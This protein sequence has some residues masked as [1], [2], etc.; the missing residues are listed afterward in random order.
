MSVIQGNRLLSTSYPFLFN[1]SLFKLDKIISEPKES[2]SNSVVFLLKGNNNYQYVLK[3]TMLKKKSNTYNELIKRNLTYV[4]TEMY[5]IMKYLI[6]QKITPHMF[7]YIDDLVNINRNKLNKYI[8]NKLLN[9]D[10]DFTYIT[11]LFNETSDKNVKLIT[12]RDFKKKVNNSSLSVN[13]KKE[14]VYNILFQILYTLEVFNK[15]DIKHNDLHTKNIFV[16]INKYNILKNNHIHSSTK[17]IYL[18]KNNKKHIV[19]LPNIG[20]DIRIY[21]FD[22]SCKQ[23]NN[24]KNYPNEINSPLLKRYYSFNQNITSNKTFDTY[25]IL[26]E[27][28]LLHSNDNDIF[29]LIIEQ[30]FPKRDLLYSGK[31]G[32]EIIDK[33]HTIFSNNKT[34]N[35]IR[36]YMASRILKENEMF[37]TITLLNIIKKHLIKLNPSN[38]IIDLYSME[39]IS[40]PLKESLVPILKATE[41][42][43]AIHKKK[44]KL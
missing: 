43:F 1:K 11:A 12:L 44:D 29:R 8:L 16:L 36:Y 31:I 17:Y 21:D 9:Y 38:K 42:K 23:K 27:L 22:R 25:K 28:A 20:L 40:K 4:E 10:R 15:I 24:F 2:G 39:Y 14:I 30:Y 37:S 41:L 7:Q 5:K 26:C 18:D 35:N 33:A 34:Y 19:L 3:V 32:S 6:K 13:K